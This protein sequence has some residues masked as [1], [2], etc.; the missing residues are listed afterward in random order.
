MAAGLASVPVIASVIHALVVRWVPLGDR[1][2]IAT[3]AYDVF[4]PHTPLI[5]QYSA[6]SRAIGQTTHSLGPMLFWLLAVPSHFFGSFATPLTMGIV[7]LGC[8][9]GSLMLVRRHGGAPLML[10]IALAVALM[11]RALPAELFHDSWNPAAGV[12]PLMLLMF[13]SWS[14]ACGEYRLLPL[15]LI[16]ASFVA[17]C[18]LTFVPPALGALVVGLIGMVIS[19]TR[20]S[21]S[22]SPVDA[23]SAAPW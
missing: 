22:S 23:R 14:L 3:R 13:V 16:V 15:A 1:A 12:L 11:A 19:L 20:R 18:H 21:A 9:V 8:I 17:Q 7:N 5:G 4:S 10:A 6:S 2:L